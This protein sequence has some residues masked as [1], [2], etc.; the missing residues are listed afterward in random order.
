M[1]EKGY[2]PIRLNYYGF[3]YR[4][5]KEGGVL[6]SFRK[7]KKK[8]DYAN[9]MIKEQS[10]K[11]TKNVFAIQFPTTVT[12]NY[13]T[14]A[15]SFDWNRKPINKK[16]EKIRLL[17]MFPWLNVGGADKFNLDLISGLNKDRYEITIITTETAPYTWRQRFEEYAEIFDLTSFLQRRD[18]AAFIHYIIK[19][20]NIDIVMESN[21]YYGYYAIPWLK[22]EFPEVVF[23]DYLHSA[24]WRWRNGAYPRDSVAIGGFFDRTYTCTNSLK[25]EMMKKMGRTVN[26]IRTVYIGVDDKKFKT[27]NVKISDVKVLE[28]NLNRIKGKK[29]ILFLCRIAEEKRPIFMIKVMKKLLEK[30]KNLMLLVV[31]DGPRIFRNL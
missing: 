21:S 25:N 4:N 31:G 26:N 2:F 3:W 22:A 6:E 7:D 10:R 5:K 1:L 9:M 13:D 20:R 27:E 23:T 30:D 18:W 29:V 12:S 14:Y 11:I 16:G 24:D 17:F 28:N 8:N 19:S 15:Y